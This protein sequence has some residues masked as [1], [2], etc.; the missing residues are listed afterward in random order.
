MRAW[1]FYT[2]RAAPGRKS[3]GRIRG[4]DAVGSRILVFFTT[5]A[6]GNAHVTSLIRQHPVDFG[7]RNVLWLQCAY[8]NVENS[9][10]SR[11]YPAAAS[12]IST[13]VAAKTCDERNAVVVAAAV[14]GVRRITAMVPARA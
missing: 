6:A 1:T 4:A 5:P 11:P 10:A 3:A 7:K 13:A 8:E 14:P 9:P 2:F 12:K